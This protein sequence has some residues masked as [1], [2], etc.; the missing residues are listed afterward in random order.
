MIFRIKEQ[1]S[2]NHLVVWFLVLAHLLT[3]SALFNYSHAGLVLFLIGW[4]LTACMG[5]TFGF[6]RMLS[7]RSFKAH[8]IVETFSAL[9]GILALQG[10]PMTWVAHHRMH[11]AGSDTEKDPHN[12]RLGFWFSHIVWLSINRKEFD[13]QPLLK[14]YARDIDRDPFY[15]FISQLWFMVLVQVA[16]GLMCYAVA[17]WSGILWGVFARLCFV[18]HVTWF[19]NSATHKFGYV[20]Y[21]SGDLSRNNWWVALLTFGEGWHNNHHSFEKICPAGHVWYE[22]D[23][24]YYIVWGLEKLGLAWD[25]EKLPANHSLNPVNPLIVPRVNTKAVS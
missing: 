8:P 4:F 17:G 24:T 6:H 5:I 25:V 22:V 9:C 14:K 20:R 3:V 2:I 13:E 15:R 23:V 16:W 10:D 18:Y 7:H 1:F 11:H 21:Q 12:A 19:V